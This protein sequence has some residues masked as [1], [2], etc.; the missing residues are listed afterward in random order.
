[1]PKSCPEE[2]F[3]LLV[4][5]SLTAFWPFVSC[6]IRCGSSWGF[7]MFYYLTLSINNVQYKFFC[8]VLVTLGRWKFDV[9]N[10]SCPF[11][12]SAHRL[13]VLLFP[14]LRLSCQL[15]C[16]WLALFFIYVILFLLSRNE[17]RT[18]C[19]A[20]C[21]EYIF[22]ILCTD[23]FKCKLLLIFLSVNTATTSSTRL[24]LFFQNF[25]MLAHTKALGGTR[26]PRLGRT[27][28]FCLIFHLTQTQTIY[29]SFPSSVILSTRFNFN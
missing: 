6:L 21:H 24:V 25:K 20:K 12:G 19:P 28:Q 27:E 2:S 15:K 17:V 7:L 14:F 16:G 1:M 26:K 18:W 13:S 23:P 10:G 29:Y 4:S 9:A 22:I 5:S 8:G 3:N 11:L